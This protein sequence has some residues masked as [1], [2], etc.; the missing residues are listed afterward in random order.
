MI[1]RN[2]YENR[3][4]HENDVLT[5]MLLPSVKCS[6]MTEPHLGVLVEHRVI[7]A[8]NQLYFRDPGVTPGAL[9]PSSVMTNAPW[10]YCVPFVMNTSC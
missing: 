3:Y 10:I 1:A 5:Q 6:A 2:N 7:E 8:P 9:M 4:K